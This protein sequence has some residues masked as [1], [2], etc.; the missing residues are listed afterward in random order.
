M[1]AVAGDAPKFISVLQMWVAWTLCTELPDAAK[2]GPAIKSAE[3]QTE[4][5][6]FQARAGALHHP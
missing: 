3:P 4:H 5:G 1:G 2:A 6:S